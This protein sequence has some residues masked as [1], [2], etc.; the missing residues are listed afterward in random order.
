MHIYSSLFKSIFSNNNSCLLW[1][2]QVQ[3]K[4]LSVHHFTVVNRVG[5]GDHTKQTE[6]TLNQYTIEND[7]MVLLRYTC[8]SWAE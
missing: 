1:I 4:A 3:V 7:R 5:R 8:S 6:F 2:T